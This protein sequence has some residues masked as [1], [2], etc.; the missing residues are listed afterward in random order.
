MDFPSLTSIF[1]FTYYQPFRRKNTSE[2]T[3]RGNVNH[4][5]VPAPCGNHRAIEKRPFPPVVPYRPQRQ[6]S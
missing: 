3:R 6:F 5:R 4:D 1:L 2:R